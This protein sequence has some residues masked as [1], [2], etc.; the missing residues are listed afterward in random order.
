MPTSIPA[1]GN[2]LHLVMLAES[3][4]LP[5]RPCKTGKRSHA[6]A[7]S[8]A[9]RAAGVAPAAHRAQA[10]RRLISILSTEIKC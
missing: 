5:E 4:G 10:H 3:N 8:L 9:L 2:T 6:L 7:A 1:H